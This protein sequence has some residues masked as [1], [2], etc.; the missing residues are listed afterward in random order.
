MSNRYTSYKSEILSLGEGANYELMY[1]NYLKIKIANLLKNP[2]V[3]ML[4]LFP[5]SFSQK[6]LNVGMYSSFSV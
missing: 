4:K 1:M 2:L 6:K 3:V 5:I